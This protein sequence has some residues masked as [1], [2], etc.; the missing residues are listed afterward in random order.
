M[1][2]YIYTQIYKNLL[3]EICEK[4]CVNAVTTNPAESAVA[5]NTDATDA[6]TPAPA[7]AL[8]TM[9]TYRNEAKHS[10]IIDLKQG[11]KNE[12]FRIHIIIYKMYLFIS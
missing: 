6:P 9:N 7:A 12:S 1:Y 10:A 11:N 4:H 5:N 3:P 2:L 8:H